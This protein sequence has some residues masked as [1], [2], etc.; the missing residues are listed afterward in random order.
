MNRWNKNL[1]TQTVTSAP[2]D[3]HQQWR[4]RRVYLCFVQDGAHA[5]A[6]DYMDASGSA[7]LDNP[8]QHQLGRLG[9]KECMDCKH[10]KID[11][12]A[13]AAVLC[14]TLACLFY[15]PTSGTLNGNS[16]TLTQRYMVWAHLI[17]S[18]GRNSEQ[19]AHIYRHPFGN[20]IRD[21]TWRP[22]GVT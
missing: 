2:V 6:G 16:Y 18:S 17:Q 14:L 15:G 4:E 3:R 7:I 8:A 10:I 9:V 5:V 12:L 19:Q 11:W 13:I 1:S 21:V 20:D 22:T